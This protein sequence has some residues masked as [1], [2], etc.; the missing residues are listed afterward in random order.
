MNRAL[1]FS[2]RMLASCFFLTYPLEAFAQRRRWRWT[3]TGFIGSFAGVLCAPYLSSLVWPC[4]L[5][6]LGAILLSVVV[7]DIAEE[8]LGT[9]DDHRIVID[10]WVGYLLTIALLPSTPALLA[11]GFVVFRGLDTVKP[12]GIKYLARLPGGWGV[13][14]DDVAAGLAGN[15][16]LRFVTMA[17]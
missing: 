15:V 9:K 11:A 12:I 13:V 3:G 4:I 6:L 16:L 7:S 5:S 1:N 8:S 17:V 10:E 14:M 2:C